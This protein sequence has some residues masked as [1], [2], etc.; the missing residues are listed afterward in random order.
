MHVK[1][2][3][4]VRVIAGKD[5][6][7][8]GIITKSLPKKERVVVEGINIAKKHSRP[9]QAD[10]VGGIKEIEMPIHV[11]NVML[12]DPATGDATRTG[13][14]EEN[15]KLVRYSKKTGETIDK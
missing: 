8:E 10:Q 13:K 3:D 12:I 2:G 11:S 15:G 6:G 14:R 1:T 9:T 7:K 4:K 5:K